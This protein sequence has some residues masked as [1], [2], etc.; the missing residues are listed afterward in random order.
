M[1]EYLRMRLNLRFHMQIMLVAR[2]RGLTFYIEYGYS[3]WRE[4]YNYF[5]SCS[6]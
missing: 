5:K 6:L 3:K 1:K 2:G 4:G